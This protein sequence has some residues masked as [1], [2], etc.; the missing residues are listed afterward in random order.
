MAHLLT[1]IG[2]CLLLTMVVVTTSTTEAI[3]F[4]APTAAQGGSLNAIRPHPS[5]SVSPPSQEAEPFNGGVGFHEGHTG[6]YAA[7][8]TFGSGEPDPLAIGFAF[9]VSPA[10]AAPKPLTLSLFSTG[11]VLAVVVRRKLLPRE[12]KLNK[13]IPR[14]L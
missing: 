5:P 1:T 10:I 3:N 2:P 8:S 14:G 13:H 11:F 7:A 9:R 4:K 6:A 12:F